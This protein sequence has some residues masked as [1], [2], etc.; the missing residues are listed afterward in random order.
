M[1]KELGKFQQVPMVSSRYSA[2]AQTCWASETTSHNAP[3]L[4]AIIPLNFINGAH[5]HGKRYTRIIQ[6][7]NNHQ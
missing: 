1:T 3:S 2:R 7:R 6:F 5:L 4:N